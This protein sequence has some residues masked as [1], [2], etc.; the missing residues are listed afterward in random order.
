MLPDRGTHFTA[1]LFRNILKLYGTTR[2]CTVSYNPQANDLTKHM[3]QTLSYIMSH[4]ITPDMRD[5]EKHVSH[6]DKHREVMFNNGDLVLLRT[7]PEQSDETNTEKLTGLTTKLLFKY[8]GPWKV[9]EK[10]SPVNYRIRLLPT[11]KRKRRLITDVV[12]VRRLK[13]YYECDCLLDDDQYHDEPLKF[14]VN[15]RKPFEK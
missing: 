9:D 2:N 10:V 14:D 11:N 12:H 8:S 6:N 5:W 15:I 13:P 4:Y 1:A 7:P 3:N